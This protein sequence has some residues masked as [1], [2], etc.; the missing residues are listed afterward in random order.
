[1]ALEDKHISYRIYLVAF[2]IFLMAI[3]IIFQLTKIQWSQGDYYR[4]L[5]K[6]RTV[7][8][9]VIPANK[10]NVYSADGSLLATSIPNYNIR[11]DAMAPKG[12]AFDKN[13][14]SLS[15]SLSKMLGKPSSFYNTQLR[16]ARSN[17]NRYLLIARD[18]SYTEYIK[19]K[20]FPMFNLGANKG[21]IITEQETV[22]EH[23][24]GKIAERTIGYDRIDEN[25]IRVGKGLEW[26]F[27]KYLNGKDGKVMK[28]KIAKGQW[29]P[30]RDVN[31]VDPQDGYDVISTIDVYIQDIAHHALLKQLKQFK[32]EHGCVIV[33]ETKTG[34]IKAISNLGKLKETDSTYF[35]TQNYAIA[36]SHEPG[37]TFK[38]VDMIALLDDNKIDTSAVFD[39][40]GGIV[41]YGKDKV[42]DSHE[43][44]YGKISL[45]RG[46]EVSSNTIMVQA[47]YENYKNNPQQFID[48]IVNMG[49]DR[50]LGLPFQG[51]GKPIV[52]KPGEKG[53]NRNT[54]PWMAFGYSVAMTPLQTLTLYNA[55]ANNG[56]MVK[57]QF[58]SEIKEWN[59]VIKKYDKQVINPKICSAETIKKLKAV[60][61]NVVKKGTGSK[62]YS[63]DFSMAGKTGTAQANYG[64]S[65]GSEKHYISSFVGYFPAD[66]PKYSC[67]VVVHKPNTS[68]NNYYG[69]DVAGPVFKRIAQK[70]FTDSPSTNEITNLNRKI[71]KQ[72]LAYDDYKIKASTEMK[73]IPN[74][75]G[76]SGMDAV[77]LLE[78]LGIKVK[79]KGIGKVKNQSIQ[80]G[81]PITKN[82]IITLELS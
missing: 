70:I 67:I 16:M 37:S 33:M 11:F 55:V 81:E 61:Q 30:I 58:V 40:K 51:E 38:L 24:I 64:H 52:H 25:G 35:E 63:K 71:S 74:L 9:F 3:G 79:L 2:S 13:V 53:W 1:M 59:N 7:R 47:V 68:G 57:P 73:V 43:G 45:A 31:E 34:K 60:L 27:R 22:R 50:P 19:I 44:G 78:N 28:Q 75:R 39:S 14:N 18:L 36:E 21:G 8:N 20:G 15:D 42:R 65:G 12:D 5:A 66:H 77:A 10:G 49:L 56:E 62:L 76:M 23:P 46:F 41:V 54:L 82:T 69:A 29:K 48:R 32:A 72:E 17:K 4:K 6:E 80:S 26:S